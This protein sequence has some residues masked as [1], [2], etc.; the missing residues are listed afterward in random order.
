MNATTKAR[1]DAQIEYGK[2]N[3][4]SA[5]REYHDARL[6]EMSPARR[7]F[8]IAAGKAFDAGILIVSYAIPAAL[9]YQF[10]A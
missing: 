9:I 10:F 6:R 1:L 3:V 5:A 8:T 7:A 4:A 2:F